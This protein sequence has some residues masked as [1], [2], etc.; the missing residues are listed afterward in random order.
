ML[1]TQNYKH[2]PTFEF[3]KVISRNTVSF[4]TSETI[5]TAFLM[6]SLLRQLYVVT[7]QY[8]E[9]M[10]EQFNKMNIQADSCQKL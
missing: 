2:R 10:S 9:K 3:V 7:W 4:F 6:T 5:K 1:P 8:K